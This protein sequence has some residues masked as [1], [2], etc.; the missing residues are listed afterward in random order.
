[1]T[2]GVE[3][4]SSAVDRSGC[5]DDV[6]AVFIVVVVAVEVFPSVFGIGNSR[7]LEPA[8]PV[9]PTVLADLLIADAVVAAA[10]VDL[11]A[12]LDIDADMV[13]S[14]KSETVYARN[15]VA[16]IAPVSSV[17]L[18]IRKHFHSVTAAIGPDQSRAVDRAGRGAAPNVAPALV[19]RVQRILGKS[20]ARARC[21]DGDTPAAYSD[22]GDRNCAERNSDDL[23]HP[24][25][26]YYLQFLN[27]NIF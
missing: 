23:F 14:G 11:H 12:V 6:L 19:I 17:C 27:K 4:I 9:V 5:I 1:M 21:T 2:L 7:Q 3:V 26:F 18:R 8:V 10:G 25:H 16:D 20:C 15:T 22:T 13:R 24:V